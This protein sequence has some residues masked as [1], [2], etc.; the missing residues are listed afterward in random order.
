MGGGEMIREVNQKMSTWNDIPWKFEAGTPNVAQV[1]GLGA[2][3]DYIEKLTIAKISTYENELLNYAQSKLQQLEGITI[4]GDV[5]NKGAI[6][7]F[8]IENIHPHDIAHI[9]DADGIAIRAGHHCAQLAMKHL[10]VSATNRVSFYIYNSFSEIDSLITSL[11][12]AI[13]LFK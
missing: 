6:I 2:A 12:K 13:D 10:N 5:E 3:I 8:N 4:F 9:L 7:S 11:N 1:I